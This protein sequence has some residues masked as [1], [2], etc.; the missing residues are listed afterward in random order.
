MVGFILIGALVVIGLK[1][2]AKTNRRLFYSLFITA[3]VAFIFSAGIHAPVT[4]GLVK[5]LLLHVPG[6]KGFRDPEKFS[7]L[8]VF[9]YAIAAG[10]GVDLVIRRYIKPVGLKFAPLLFLLLP[11]IYVPT[12]LWGFGGQLAPV[13]YPKSWYVFNNRLKNE[14]GSYKVLFLPWHQ[15][16]SYDF[17]PRIIASPA[18]RFFNTQVIAGDNAEFGDIYRDTISPTSDYIEQQILARSS[19]T[20][21][22]QK[23]ASIQVKYVLLAQGYDSILYGFLDRQGD[24]RL[25][26]NQPGLRVYLNQAYGGTSAK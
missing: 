8:V 22:A 11:L 2:L 9:A 7:A 26:S 15:Y 20:D 25:I 21:L 12:M 24:L 10:F 13:S 5:N 16:M 18:P 6:L 1:R 3:V 23:L 14:P 17:S 19:E 4:G